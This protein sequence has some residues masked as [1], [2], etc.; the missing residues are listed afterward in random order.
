MAQSEQPFYFFLTKTNLKNLDTLKIDY[1]GEG[2]IPFSEY[3]DKGKLLAF[4]MM[5]NDSI[6][7]QKYK[8]GFH[9]NTISKT[10]SIGKTMISVLLDKAI[11]DGYI[12]DV[13]QKVKE[14]IPELK[15]K[16]NFNTMTIKKLFPSFQQ[17]G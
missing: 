17:N 2:L 11:E 12:K 10:F 13:N 3:F 15:D 5:R 8:D 14:F 6:I 4:V 1:H 9:E 7:C 16:P